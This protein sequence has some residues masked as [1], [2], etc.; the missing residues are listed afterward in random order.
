M[1]SRTP[2]STPVL[3]RM[4]LW[5]AIATATL[6]GVGGAVGFLVAGAEGLWS[7]LVAV[8]MA[9]IFM[10][11][12]TA[13]ILIANRWYGDALFVPIFFGS[14]MGGWILK[15]IVFLVALFLLRDQPWLAPLVFLVALIAS[16]IASLVIDVAVMLRMRIPA[17]SDATLPTAAD[18]EAAERPDG[19]SEARR[20]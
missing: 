19:D 18:I 9:A 14:V 3:R 6:A 8:L 4:L 2:S 5:S 1:T 17:V 20:D 15:F 13:S 10:A 16:I 12:T 11:F 7:A